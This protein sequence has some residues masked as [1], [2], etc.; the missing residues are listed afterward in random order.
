[1]TAVHRLRVGSQTISLDHQAGDSEGRQ[2]VV[3]GKKGHA[4]ST[5]QHRSGRSLRTLPRQFLFA[6]FVASR[7]LKKNPREGIKLRQSTC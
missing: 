4:F 1:M 5:R 7:S 6:Y 3:P 2:R